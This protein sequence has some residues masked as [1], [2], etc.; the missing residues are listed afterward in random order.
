MARADG[1]G[2]VEQGAAGSVDPQAGDRR[3]GFLAVA[4]QLCLVV[5]RQAGVVR[6]LDAHRGAVSCS[7]RGDERLRAPV[8]G[9]AA[10]YTYADIEC[11]L[12]RP[13]TG[14]G[15][16][17]GAGQ[18]EGGGDAPDPDAGAGAEVQAQAQLV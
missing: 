18:S 13:G 2:V 3:A 17:A 15:A 8:E 7:V 6:H 1:E 16:R 5:P 12:G 11:R 10:F 14:A 4:A 9:S